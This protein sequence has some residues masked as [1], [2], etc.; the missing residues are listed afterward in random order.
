M[1]RLILCLLPALAAAQPMRVGTFAQEVRTVHLSGEDVRA[2]VVEPSGRVCAQTDAGTSCLNGAAWTR[3]QATF[4]DTKSATSRD[5]RIATAS[6]DGL[7][8]NRERQFPKSGGR[9]WAPVDVRG[10]AFDAR[11]RL[12]FAS[13]QGVGVL[14]GNQW[15]LYTGAE[16]L[17]Y[18]DFTCVAA[19]PR[20]AIWF[21]THH[22]AIRFDSGNW[23]YR[24]G[25]PWLPDDDVRAIAVGAA[26]DAWIATRRG[27]S[28]I[29]RRPMTLAEKARTFEAEIDRRHRRTPYGFVLEVALKL[30]GDP[31][32]WTQH[33]SDND[34]LWTAMYGAGECFAAAATKSEDAYRRATAAFEA[35]RFLGSVTQG[36]E[37]PAPPGFVARTVVPADGPDPNL[38]DGPDRDQRMR[39][40][41]DHLWKIMPTRWPLSADR[42][43][44]WK[45]DTSSDELD[46]HYFLYGVYYDLAARTEEEKRR[47]REQVAGLTDHLIDHG[48][49]LVDHDGKPTRWGIFDPAN[50]NH[51]VE[52]WQERGI[53]SL[54]M[55][56]YLK[57]AAHIT[58][59]PKY[60]KH[61]RALIEQ[62]AYAENVLIPKSNSGPGSGNQS[63][64]EMIFMSYYGLLRYETDP[65]LRKK[66]LWAFHNHWKMEAPEMNP[67]FNFLYA[68]IATGESFADAFNITPL[69]PTGSW[70]EDSVDTLRRFP[71]D[72][73][74]WGFRNS[75]RI[76]VVK[77]PEYVGGGEGRGHRVNGKVIPVDERFISHWNHDPW[78]LDQSGD[79]RSLTDGSAFLLPYYLGLYTGAIRE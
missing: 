77:L 3:A 44:Y 74:S 70:L 6:P 7:F 21:G 11:D 72:R 59:D 26:G 35:L 24:A 14:D 37:H 29:E 63:D 49:R 60:E 38:R 50:L 31:S 75:H 40:A 78:R 71:L 79:G 51:N 10:V 66:Y 52:W 28:H 2:V 45:S 46:G 73:I 76:D 13:P 16:G 17:P 12:W 25:L 54:S 64:D 53:N 5:G 65:A 47:V 58:G 18:N 15:T 34:G 19:G 48:Y 20:G 8:L 33:D 43:W 42:K 69:A 39:V 56:S 1:K 61:Y 41:R 9:S 68:A 32:E 67:F 4:P 62:H 27:L 23:E 30:P 57:V 36:G 55:L 22:G